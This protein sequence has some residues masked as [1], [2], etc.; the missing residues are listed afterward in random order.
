MVFCAFLHYDAH[1]KKVSGGNT[2]IKKIVVV[3]AFLFLIIL[4][5]VSVRRPAVLKTP[6]LEYNYFSSEIT[7]DS[8]DNIHELH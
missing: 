2:M 3:S 1:I 6:V 5:F 4:S 8:D 7:D